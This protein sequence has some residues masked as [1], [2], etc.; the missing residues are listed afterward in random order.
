MSITIIVSASDV[1]EEAVQDPD[2]FGRIL[3]YMGRDLRNPEEARDFIGDVA[4]GLG[5][6]A[7]RLVKM[8]AAALSEDAA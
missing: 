6:D 7:M 3:G 5:D 4:G 2:F 8:L 1:A